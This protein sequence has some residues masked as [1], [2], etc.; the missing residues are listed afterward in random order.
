MKFC[1]SV[2]LAYT[3][4]YASGVVPAKVMAWSAPCVCGRGG[5]GLDAKFKVWWDSPTLGQGGWGWE[6]SSLLRSGMAKSPFSTR[7][8]APIRKKNIS[9]KASQNCHLGDFFDKKVLQRMLVQS[10][11]FARQFPGTPW[12]QTHWQGW[13]EGWSGLF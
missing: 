11:K 2:P 6:D 5:A 4:R 12:H 9:S 7:H 10:S 13:E 1:H 8:F 3:R